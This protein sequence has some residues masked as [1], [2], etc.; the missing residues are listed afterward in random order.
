MDSLLYVKI[1][2]G[3]G[4]CIHCSAVGWNVERHGLDG[5]VVDLDGGSRTYFTIWGCTS[6]YWGLLTRR[7]YSSSPFLSSFSLRT[8]GERHEGG[9]YKMEEGVAS[10]LEVA[11][12]AD[13]S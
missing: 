12:R 13:K 6:A 8:A 1:E 9:R 4:L 11:T 7:L 3:E 10:D 2:V 5:W